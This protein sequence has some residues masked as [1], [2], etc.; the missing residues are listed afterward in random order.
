MGEGG[1]HPG[2][3]GSSSSRITTTGTAG[4]RPRAPTTSIAAQ[5][6]ASCPMA[7]S[8]RPAPS[9][10]AFA[11][12]LLGEVQH[13]DITTNRYVS[14]RWRYYSGVR[15]G[16]LARQQQA[17][18]QLRPALRDTRRRPWRA[19]IPTATRTST[20]T[21]RIRPPAAG[22]ARRSSPATDRAA[23]ARGR[24]TTRGRGGSARGS[25]S[26]TAIDSETV[27][28]FSAARTFG[29]VKNTGGSSH[30]N[31]FIGGYNVTAPALPGQ[32]RVQLGQPAGPPGRSRRSSCLRR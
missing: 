23:P 10:N 30:W 15:A 3:S 14:D 13:S 27:A 19:T 9:G 32:L 2:S 16:R 26:S 22:S 21:C 1:A 18:L 25:A 8:T 28:R 17:D 12:F 7:R 5:P 11:T 6:P 4:T 24:C 31:G 20:R 29:S